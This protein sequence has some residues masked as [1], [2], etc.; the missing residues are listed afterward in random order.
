MV[1][2]LTIISRS[3]FSNLYKFGHIYVHNAVPFEGKLSDHADDKFLFDA[4]TAYMDTYE[5]STEYLLLHIFKIPFHR[6]SL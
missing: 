4:V 3:D 5:Y 1:N 2:Y 6:L